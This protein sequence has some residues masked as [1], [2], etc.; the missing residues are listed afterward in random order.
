MSFVYTGN[1]VSQNGSLIVRLF[2]LHINLTSYNN[3]K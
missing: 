3:K 1:A 2:A